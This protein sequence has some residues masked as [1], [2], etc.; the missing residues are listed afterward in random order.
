MIPISDT[1]FN[2]LSHGSLVT[3]HFVWGQFKLIQLLKLIV[4]TYC[5]PGTTYRPILFKL[6]MS[7]AYGSPR[8]PDYMAF[9]I[10][11]Q[12]NAAVAFKGNLG[13]YG[14]ILLKLC[15]DVAYCSPGTTCY[16]AFAIKGRSSFPSKSRINLYR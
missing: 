14:P 8:T 11:D 13:V 10:K 7:L 12:S 15:V 1:N 5:P 6:C 4:Q 16:V 2:A 9:A 3:L